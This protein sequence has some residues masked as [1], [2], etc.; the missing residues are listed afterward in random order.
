[1]N[2]QKRII[3]TL[4]ILGSLASAHSAF[5]TNGYFFHG[6][7]IKSQGQAGVSIAQPKDALA[8]ANNPAGTVWIGDRLDLGATIFAPDRN[9]EI[10]GSANPG[11]NG[12]FNGNQK[13]YFLIPE[14]GYSTQLTDQLAAG[15]SIYA[16]GGMN[17]GYNHNPFAAYGST[18]S[19][20]VDFSQLFIIPSLAYKFTGHQSIGI[21]VNYV[22]QRF[23]SKGLAAFANPAFPVVLTL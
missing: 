19:A 23:T 6:Y 1:M 8:A 20:G 12:S 5:A 9:A 11:A 18:G 17:T 16:N 7:G 15:V 10:T 14:I 13:N 2:K 22:Y 21:G 3:T 4:L